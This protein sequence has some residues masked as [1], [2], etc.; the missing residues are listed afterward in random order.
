MATDQNIGQICLQEVASVWQVDDAAVKWVDG[1]FDW[2]PGSHLVRVRALPNEKPGTQDRWRVSIETDFLAS[3]PIEDTKFINL[4]ARSC[5][6]TSTY[7][8]LMTSTYSMQYP[9]AE[10]LKKHKEHVGRDKLQALTV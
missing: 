5:S 3:V 10:I 7:S 4:I 1:G 8:I 9:P 2:R 6:M